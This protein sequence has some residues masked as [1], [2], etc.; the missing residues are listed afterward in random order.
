MGT[1]F[2]DK[3]QPGKDLWKMM[4]IGGLALAIPFEMAAGPF[5]GFFIGMYLK[6]KLGLHEYIMY[7]F[8]LMGFVA[9]F[10]NT[11]VIIK[12]MIKINKK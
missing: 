10:I 12:M 3:K 11:A 7:I 2:I 5:I 4:Q 6:S 1:E 8:I 9:G